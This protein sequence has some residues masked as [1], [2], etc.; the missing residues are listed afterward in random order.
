MNEE[1]R[2]R[3]GYEDGEEDELKESQKGRGWMG[4]N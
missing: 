4:R 3:E 1:E 2:G